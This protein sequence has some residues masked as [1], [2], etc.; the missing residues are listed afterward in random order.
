ML[1]GLE[2][3]PR[4]SRRP[5]EGHE[6]EALLEWNERALV[7]SRELSVSGPAIRG[8]GRVAVMTGTAVA[9]LLAA[10]RNLTRAVVAFGVGLCA[11]LWIAQTGR[12]ANDRAAQ[13]R[14]AW[15]KAR[16]GD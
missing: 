4:P 10:E 9:L 1:R 15:G 3:A 2:R 6:A 8:L 7:A 11:S 5:N 12:L 14:S 13:L 16:R